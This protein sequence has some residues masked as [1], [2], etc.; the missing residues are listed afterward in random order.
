M[1]S[2]QIHHGADMF[3]IISFVEN[4]NNSKIYDATHKQSRRKFTMEVT[5]R[6]SNANMKQTPD[7]VL[8]THN[9][10][11]SKFLSELRYTFQTKTSDYFILTHMSK[12]NN[13]A[14]LFEIYQVLTEA[15]AKFIIIEI[16]AALE[17]LHRSGVTY[18]SVTK[19]KI[20]FGQ[21]GHIFLKRTF[22]GQT[23]WTKEE[24]YNCHIDTCEN[25]YHKGLIVT[26]AEATREW[27]SVGKLFVELLT[28]EKRDI[29]SEDDQRKLTSKLASDFS[30]QLIRK[31]AVLSNIKNHT[32][33]NTVNWEMV[34]NKRNKVPVMFTTI[35]Q[36]S[37]LTIYPTDN[38]LK[39]C[40]IVTLTVYLT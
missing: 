20:F 1:L 5:P 24:C 39:P 34:K 8:K 28:G 15:E 19:E 13:L 33:L 21:E 37:K 17:T 18:G 25:L 9:Q 36:S 2:P 35:Y 12:V 10:A 23:Y 7:P 32:F 26:I 22:C 6:N 31:D 40:H 29:Y 11:P 38:N 27:V 4:G 3:E 14:S 16:I 30:F